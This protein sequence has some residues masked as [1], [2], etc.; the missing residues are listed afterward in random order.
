MMILD[1][2]KKAS[3]HLQLHLKCLQNR[4]L[5]YKSMFSKQTYPKFKFKKKNDDIRQKKI[6]SLI[7]RAKPVS[8]DV[9]RLVMLYD[10]WKYLFRN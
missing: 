5:S 8:C 6:K 10:H 9:T 4:T 3:F 7:A 2:K 1:K